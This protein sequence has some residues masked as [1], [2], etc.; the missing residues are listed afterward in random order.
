MIQTGTRPL[1]ALR[2][3]AFKHTIDLVGYDLTG[4]TFAAQ[5]RLYRDAPG[6]PLISLANSVSPAEGISVTVA[7]TDGIPTSTIEMRINEVT[8][9]GVL[10][11][12]VAAG[13]PNRK[14][15]SDVELVWDIHVTAT[16]LPKTRLLEGPFT[17]RAG[18]TQ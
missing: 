13:V 5:M 12:T 2:W 8:I 14:A 6:A 15:G 7:T 1:V 18:S 11:F 17:I 9:E 10:P 3:Q 16:G 4:G